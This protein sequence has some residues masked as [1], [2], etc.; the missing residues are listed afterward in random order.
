MD[1]MEIV[2]HEPNKLYGTLHYGASVAQHQS[3]GSSYVLPTGSFDQQFHVYSLLWEQDTVKILV[4]DQ[5]YLSATSANIGNLAYP[6]NNN[7]FFI[8][9]V[10]VGGDWP[11][12]PDQTTVFPARMAVDYVRV[13]KKQ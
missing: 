5:E 2:G 4:D 11:G 12:S 1:I 7:F 6:F 10:A 8:F 13:F 3:T 9:N